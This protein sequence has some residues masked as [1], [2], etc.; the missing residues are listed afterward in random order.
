M[1]LFRIILIAIA[2]F[3]VYRLGRVLVRV[4]S[5]QQETSKGGGTVG[6]R[7]QARPL[8]KPFR[9]A[10]DASFED[11]TGTG[12]KGVYRDQSS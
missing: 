7:K 3:F 8:D 5:R 1:S 2:A 10:K 9:D 6:G 12:N 11:L 4:F